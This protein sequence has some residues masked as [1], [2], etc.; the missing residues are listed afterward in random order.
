MSLIYDK[1][2]EI[3]WHPNNYKHFINKGYNFTKFGDVFLCKTID[4][5]ENS[6]IK[7]EVICDYCGK[8]YFT[9]FRKIYKNLSSDNEIDRKCVCCK[10]CL[11]KKLSE[12]SMQKYGV[13]YTSKL[14]STKQKY[15]ET[16]NKKYG[17]NNTFQV[18]E[19]KE[20]SKLTCIEKYNAKYYNQTEEHKE[21]VRNT[22]LKKYGV[23][24]FTKSD[25]IKDK[26]RKTCIKKYGVDYLMKD[27]EYS[28]KIQLKRI[29]TMYENNN[30]PCSSQQKYIYNLLNNNNI[31]CE[32]NYPFLNCWLDIYILKIL[33]Y[34]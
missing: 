18:E 6:C 11:A 29:K 21:R 7:V 9:Q 17:C 14:D 34:I 27:K 12:L 2:M 30:A 10:K 13:S 19:F 25:I 23:D 32:L 33:Q 8:H 4:L 31:K 1:I 15:I 20:K 22:S 28:K 16:C 26:C 5:K 3:K 24:H